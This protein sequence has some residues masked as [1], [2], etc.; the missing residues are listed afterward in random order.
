MM[1]IVDIG[2]LWDG[3]G[4]AHQTIRNDPARDTLVEKRWGST[5]HMRTTAE[6]GARDAKCPQ[7]KENFTVFQGK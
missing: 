3:G 5:A 2:H 1:G 7:M 6:G 4:N